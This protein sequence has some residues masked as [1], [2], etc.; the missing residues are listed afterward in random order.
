MRS[1][2]TNATAI[3]AFAHTAPSKADWE[4]VR[5]HLLSVAEYASKVL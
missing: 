3:S 5:K 4:P 2:P 1:E